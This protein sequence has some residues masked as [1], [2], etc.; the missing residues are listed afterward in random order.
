MR[1][2]LSIAL[3]VFVL[4]NVVYSETQQKSSD[5]K[6]DSTEEAL[7]ALEKQLWALL[8]QRELKAYASLMADDYYTILPDGKA[9]TK[10]QVIKFFENEFVLEDYSLSDFHV[11]MFNKEAGLIVYKADAQGINKG[12]EATSR[13]AAVS[14]WAKRDGKWLNVFYQEHFIKYATVSH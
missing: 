1:F 10:D 2:F 6:P 9:Y 14:G 8:K 11:V 12:T 7:I 5:T 13:A 4:T 3:V